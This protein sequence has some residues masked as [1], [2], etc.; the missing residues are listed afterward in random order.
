MNTRSDIQP[1]LYFCHCGWVSHDERFTLIWH[2]F[3]HKCNVGLIG[4][5]RKDG[6]HKSTD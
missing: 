5:I 6:T 1:P 2:R 3:K 4:R